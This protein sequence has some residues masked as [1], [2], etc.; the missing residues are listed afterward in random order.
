MALFV[1][2]VLFMVAAKI[3]PKEQALVGGRKKNLSNLLFLDI[4]GCH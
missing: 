3:P 1:L 2:V 4:Y